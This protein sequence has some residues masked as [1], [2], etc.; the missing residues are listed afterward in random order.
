MYKLEGVSIVANFI[1]AYEESQEN[2]DS[3][4]LI[5][6]VFF[7]SKGNLFDVYCVNY[8]PESDYKLT[9]V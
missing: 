6:S 5:R 8:S 9:C 3:H 2:R 4:F 1:T 7:V